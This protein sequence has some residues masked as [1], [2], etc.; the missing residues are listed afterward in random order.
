MKNNLLSRLSL[1]YVKGKETIE[2]E[3]EKELGERAFGIAIIGVGASINTNSEKIDDLSLIGKRVYE[4]YAQNKRRIKE[5]IEENKLFPKNYF[6]KL[7]FNF[8]YSPNL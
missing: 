7:V 2:L 5:K 6:E 1:A 8:G 4:G 3:K